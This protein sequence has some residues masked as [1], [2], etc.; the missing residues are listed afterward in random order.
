MRGKYQKKRERKAIGV[1][2]ARLAEIRLDET[3]I[4]KRVCTAL[5][6]AG[7]QNLLELAKCTDKQ[8]LDMKNIGQAALTQIHETMDSNA[9]AVKYRS[10][11]NIG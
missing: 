7:V 5:S 4:S 1:V 11:M 9:D 10:V 3:G 6:E 2:E 8:L